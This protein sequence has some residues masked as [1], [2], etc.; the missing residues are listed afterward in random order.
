ME[1][2]IRKFV[3]ALMNFRDWTIAQWFFTF[4]WFLK[5]F[6]ADAAINTTEKFGRFL[7]MIFPRTKVA[8]KNLKHA[9][10][11]KSDAEIEQI[12]RDMWGNLSRTAAEYAYLDKIF[13][14]DD[15]NPTKSRFEIAGSENFEK[16][17]EL[18]GPAI[19]FTAHTGNWE[20]LPVG[21]AAYGVNI[22]ALFRAP[23]NKYIAE[24][25]LATRTTSSGH[26]VPSKAGAA[27]ALARIMDKGGKVGLLIDQYYTRRGIDVDFFGR[28]TKANPLLAKLARQYDCPVFPARCIRLPNGR[29]RLELQ[30]PL[31]I[32]RKENGDIDADLLTQKINSKV[33]EWVRE[34]PE[35]W[36]WLHRRWR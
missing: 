4:M 6:P 35:Q 3:I 1:T 7:G 27:W 12:L 17:A 8:R 32:P 19:C 10:P 14:F 13:D 5:L 26:L 31:E 34:Y 18:E 20:L 16:L 15:Q 25:V 36:L 2:L 28:T 29:F 30:A 21:S 11:E 33:E 9:F 23:N 22:T 24:R